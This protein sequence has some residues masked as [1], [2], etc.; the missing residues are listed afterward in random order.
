M[1]ERH[2]KSSTKL[3]RVYDNMKTRCYNKNNINYK[4]YGAKG[5]TICDEWLNSF[6]SFYSWAMFN[7]YDVSLQL[8]KDILCKANNIEPK[9]YSPSTCQWVSQNINSNNREYK[10]KIAKEEHATIISLYS[11]PSMTLQKLADKYN[12]SRDTIHKI[13]RKIQCQR[14]TH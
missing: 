5:V 2:G 8:D 6:D 13:V 3:Y 9:I 4:N 10:L 11:R 14:T 12:V 1:R 7:G